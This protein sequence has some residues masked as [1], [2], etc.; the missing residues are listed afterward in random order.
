MKF[1]EKHQLH[2]VHLLEKLVT[3]SGC[4]CEQEREQEEEIRVLKLDL[5]TIQ[6]DFNDKKEV[7]HRCESV[8]EQLTQELDTAHGELQK[9]SDKMSQLEHTIRDIQEQLALALTQVHMSLITPSSIDD[10]R[11]LFS[12]HTVLST[13]I[14]LHHSCQGGFISINDDDVLVG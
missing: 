8:I 11:I 10:Y 6:T 2:T 1:K 5:D 12:Y 3:S 4:V 7:I 14:D 13:C 9:A